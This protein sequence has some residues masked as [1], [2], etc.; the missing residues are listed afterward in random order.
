MI[1]QMNKQHLIDAIRAECEMSAGQA[2]AVVNVLI[3][4]MTDQLAA[5]GFWLGLTEAD[6]MPGTRPP[7]AR[8]LARQRQAIEH[9]A[10]T[11]LR[12]ADMVIDPDRVAFQA[13]LGKLTN[14]QRSK[15]NKN[16]T[17]DD[18]KSV[19]YYSGIARV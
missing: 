3:A 10:A 8:R 15:Y 19:R 1:Q 11:D 7:I 4:A 2:D 18:I 17:P 5:G 9:R 13:A 14:W 16:G 6:T 12:R